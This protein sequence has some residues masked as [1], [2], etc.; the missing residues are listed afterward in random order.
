MIFLAY[1]LFFSL[2]LLIA[3][4]D[5]ELMYASNQQ[6]KVRQS[7]EPPAIGKMDL[8]L[9][10][11]DPSLR[12]LTLTGDFDIHSESNNIENI[13]DSLHVHSYKSRKKQALT[14]NEKILLDKSSF[15]QDIFLFVSYFAPLCLTV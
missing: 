12:K 10:S 2:V 9:N 1:V 15:Q 14:F 5:V 6:I 13:F 7:Y 11:F 3:Y 8:K 4:F